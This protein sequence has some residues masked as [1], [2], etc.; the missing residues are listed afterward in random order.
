[1]HACHNAT[2]LFFFPSV[3]LVWLDIGASPRHTPVN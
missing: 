3:N 1:M 2:H